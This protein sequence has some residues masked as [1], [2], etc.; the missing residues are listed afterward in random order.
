MRLSSAPNPGYLYCGIAS[1]TRLL[2]CMV[3]KEAKNPPCDCFTFCLLQLCSV[4]S[5]NSLRSDTFEFLTLPFLHRQ[6][7]IT[8]GSKDTAFWVPLETSGYER[9]WK[10]I[11]WFHVW[12]QGVWKHSLEVTCQPRLISRGGKNRMWS[13]SGPLSF[14]HFFCGK[15]KGLRLKDKYKKSWKAFT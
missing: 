8:W 6:E 14:V 4:N 5:K 1:H 13:L 3:K 7:P 15:R 12:P 2:F 11:E 9:N 10:D